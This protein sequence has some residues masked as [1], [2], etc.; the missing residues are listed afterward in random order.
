MRVLL[1]M[2]QTGG[3]HRAAAEAIRAHILLEVPGADVQVVDAI[4][5][6]SPFW[7]GVTGLYGPLVRHAPWAW[8]A[9]YQTFQVA[10]A[11]LWKAT[12][13]VAFQTVKARLLEYAEEKR[14]DLVCSTHPLI[15]QACQAAREEWVRR[16]NA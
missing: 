8:G 15:N 2:S 1:L 10:G 12:Q 14:P 11:P 7:S 5:E 3:G 9:L 13:Q 16:G 4:A 6:I